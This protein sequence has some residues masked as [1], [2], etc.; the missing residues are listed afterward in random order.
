MHVIASM[1]PLARSAEASVVAPY[2]RLCARPSNR[3]TPNTPLR[4]GKHPPAL[5]YGPS[6]IDGQR[7]IGAAQSRSAPP[8]SRS[9]VAPIPHPRKRLPQIHGDG[10]YNRIQSKYFDFDM[11]GN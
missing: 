1:K 6:M 11:Y 10:T 4:V 5:R 2:A 7:P 8:L 9:C 3:N